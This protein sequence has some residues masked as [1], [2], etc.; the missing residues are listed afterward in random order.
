M[1]RNS[2]VTDIATNHR[3]PGGKAL[4][5][6]RHRWNGIVQNLHRGEDDRKQYED[7]QKYREYL[8]RESQSMTKDWENSLEKIRE[9]KTR[10]RAM[11]EQEKIQEGKALLYS[12][13]IK[14]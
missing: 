6:N 3:M 14:M 13:N 11:R 1:I 7:E 9:K 5:L 12:P 2:K 4:I 8:L 10:E